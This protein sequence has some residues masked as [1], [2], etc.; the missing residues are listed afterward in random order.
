MYTN[1]NN[2]SSI[3]AV[4]RYRRVKTI[5]NKALETADLCGL[6][7][8]ILVYDPQYH[9]L[10]EHY[11]APDVKLDCI[12]ELSEARPNTTKSRQKYR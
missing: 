5:V 10:K 3:K 11:T 6:K 2:Q 9:R 4:Q 12:T 8:N 7:L 1:S